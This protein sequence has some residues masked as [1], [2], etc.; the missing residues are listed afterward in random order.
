[1]YTV[2]TVVTIV[3]SVPLTIVSTSTTTTVSP[4]ASTVSTVLTNTV[5]GG[6]M[7]VSDLVTAMVSTRPVTR[8]VSGVPETSTMT[9]SVC[10]QAATQ[11]T[12][13]RVITR[14]WIR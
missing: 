9:E 3:V 7:T 4:G 2:S 11:L 1:V 14:W 6:A 5:S 13:T 12:A 10:P 8:S